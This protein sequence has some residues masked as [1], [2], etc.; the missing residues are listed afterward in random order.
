MI[1]IQRKA[2]SM[3]DSVMAS[4][5]GPKYRCPFHLHQLA[6]IAYVTSG[7]LL[8]K[9]LDKITTAK[10]GDMIFIPPYQPHA[11]FS[12]DGKSVKIWLLLF[13]YSLALDVFG[14]VS[15]FDRYYDVVF[16]PSEELALFISK[17]L[18]D[19]E[20]QLVNVSKKELPKIKAII[21][22]ILNEYMENVPIVNKQSG[23]RS[24][25]TVDTLKYLSAHFKDENLSLDAISHSIGYSCS[26]ISHTLNSAL[27]VN[28]KTLINSM[29]IDYAKNLL[30]SG[31]KSIYNISIES[32][33]SCERSFH[34]AFKKI[35]GST[36]L[37]YKRS[38][39]KQ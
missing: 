23:L 29:K 6:E 9:T 3:N 19:T 35:T 39:K 7:E 32:G 14:D 17:Q 30:L 16:T 5:H 24:N 2:F 18:I 11:Y 15:A 12:E 10:A 25:P 33:F 27:G 26:Q 28:L 4:F 1:K 8:V 36:P 31:E 13:S 22:P 21:Y 38:H 20:E 34:R 37:E